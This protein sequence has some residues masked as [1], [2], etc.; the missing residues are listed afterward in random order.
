MDHLSIYLSIYNSVKLYIYLSI[1]IYNS[2]YVFISYLTCK[3]S[4]MDHLSIY[5]YLSISLSIIIS[6]YL[7]LSIYIIL[8]LSIFLYIYPSFP[9]YLLYPTMILSIYLSPLTSIESE[10]NHQ[11]IS[12]SINLYIYLS[13]I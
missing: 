9:P 7:S 4:K 6:I 8:S 13:P 5:I 3:E 2:S 1:S 11:S 12:L 10:M